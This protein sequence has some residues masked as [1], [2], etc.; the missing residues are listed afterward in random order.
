MLLMF[1]TRNSSNHVL[2][3][4]VLK[5]SPKCLA[6]TQP[7]AMAL[8]LDYFL[9]QCSDLSEEHAQLAANYHKKMDA[10][11]LTVVSTGVTRRLLGLVEAAAALLLSG[12][13]PKDTPLS[14][15]SRAV[16]EKTSG[17]GGAVGAGGVETLAG[18][19]NDDE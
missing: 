6:A 11:S 3:F 12:A 8:E 14:R 18:S 15:L 7:V 1:K 4:S 17:D 16:G 10:A 19:S 13:A 9:R 5:E 2:C